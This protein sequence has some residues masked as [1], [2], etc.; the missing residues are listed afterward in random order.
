MI[1]LGDYYELS[2]IATYQSHQSSDPYAVGNYYGNYNVAIYNMYIWDDDQNGWEYVSQ[3]TISK[4][5]GLSAIEIIKMARAG[6]EAL[7]YPEEPR[8]TKPTRW[9]RYE[10]LFGFND[11]YTSTAAWGFSELTLYGRKP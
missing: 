10:A 3:H 8:F 2:R 11:N 7:M 5:V 6:D 9:F 1:D 4:P